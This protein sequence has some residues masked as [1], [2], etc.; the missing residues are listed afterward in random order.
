M[1][2]YEN[3]DLAVRC[4]Y[5]MVELKCCLGARVQCHPRGWCVTCERT[6]VQGERRFFRQNCVLQRVRSKERYQNTSCTLI[7]YDGELKVSSMKFEL[8][9][10]FHI[11]SSLLNLILPQMNLERREQ[12]KQK[13]Y[14]QIAASNACGL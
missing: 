7:G 8:F 14:A 12:S 9:L 2:S 5:E 6:F 13:L 1:N 3:E 11:K 4:L 10:H